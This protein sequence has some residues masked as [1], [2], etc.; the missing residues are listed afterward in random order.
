M[1]EE[2]I[3]HSSEFTVQT[4][5]GEIQSIQWK[6]KS[7]PVAEGNR[8]YQTY[9]KSVE[10][11][12]AAPSVELNDT[13]AKW[14]EVRAKRDRLIDGIEWRVVRY[15]TQSDAGIQTDDTDAKY[16]EILTYL[17]TLRDI[18]RTYATP[19]DVVWPAVPE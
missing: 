5:D 10:Q 6:N 16:H 7:I 14:S 1:I 11:Y 12:G 9:L 3:P 2:E 17:Q 4:Y 15:R 8:D 13:A 18:T 19:D